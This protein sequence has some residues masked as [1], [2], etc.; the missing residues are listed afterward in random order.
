MSTPPNG[1]CSNDV[2][3]LT[4]EVDL[5]TSTVNFGMM[6]LEYGSSITYN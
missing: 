6:R 4:L 2:T 1:G 3:T 5:L